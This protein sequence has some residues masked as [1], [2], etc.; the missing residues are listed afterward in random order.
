MSADTQQPQIQLPDAQAAG[1]LLNGLYQDVFFG[2]LAELGYQPQT[3]EDAHAMLTIGYQLD[4]AEQAQQKAASHESP[5][6][7]AQRLLSEKLAEFGLMP[8]A[9]PDAVTKQAAAALARD[10]NVYGAILALQT[11]PEA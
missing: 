3:A 4:V 1:E 2:K 11:Q 8:P 5:I 6:V 7:R 9:D 10:P